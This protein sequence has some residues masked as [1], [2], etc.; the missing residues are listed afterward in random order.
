MALSDHTHVATNL[1]FIN[2]KTTL[3][4]SY[5]NRVPNPLSSHKILY[6][7]LIRGKLKFICHPIDPSARNLFPYSS[8]IQIHYMHTVFQQVHDQQSLTTL[9]YH[10]ILNETQNSHVDFFIL[11]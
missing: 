10:H 2:L 4:A 6:I 11:G 3:L 5:P 8:G 7:S 1:N 9:Q